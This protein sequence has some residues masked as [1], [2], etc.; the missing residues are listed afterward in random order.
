MSTFV[1]RGNGGNVCYGEQALNSDGSVNTEVRTVSSS[2]LIDQNDQIIIYNG[3]AGTLTLPRLD[4]LSDGHL[5]TI[6]VVGAGAATLAA[7]PIDGTALDGQTADYVLEPG[8]RV[9]VLKGGTLW[10]LKG[11]GFSVLNAAA[12]KLDALIT[13]CSDGRL[14]VGDLVAA[15][16]DADDPGAA[17]HL[18]GTVGA[19]GGAAGTL[20]MGDD[21]LPGMGGEND[22]I[23]RA[24]DS[25]ASI[26]PKSL[27]FIFLSDGAELESRLLLVGNG[28]AK[29]HLQTTDGA[30]ST[31]TEAEDQPYFPAADMSIE[32][33]NGLASPSN[34]LVFGV[35][36]DGDLLI[37]ANVTAAGGTPGADADAKLEVF[38]ET[39]ASL[40]FVP[41]YTAGW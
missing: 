34:A 30:L 39:G 35:K 24:V 31:N 16:F 19:A 25:S 33:R 36:K 12:R 15:G 10:A 4:G 38:D 28:A 32:V 11:W 20:R 5:I 22:Y 27:Q 13:A 41:I 14:A 21:G 26:L 8:A 6:L 40:G 3:G 1:S 37:G 23:M 2:E 9:D 17:L 18:P 7:N 29:L